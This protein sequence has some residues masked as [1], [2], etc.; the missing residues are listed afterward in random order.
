ME[1][2]I[3]FADLVGSTELLGSS[4]VREMA[5]LLRRF[6]EQVWDLVSVGGGRVVKLIG[7]EAMIVFAEPAQA[8]RVALDLIAVSEHP[9]RSASRRHRGQPLRELRGTVNLAARLVNEADPSA[10]LVSEGVRAGGGPGLA[11]EA[12]EPLLLKGFA[13]AVPAFGVR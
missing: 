3:C 8:C 7:D 9:V 11:F 2:T 10:L 1:R 6:E 13:G 4:S 12:R 5:T